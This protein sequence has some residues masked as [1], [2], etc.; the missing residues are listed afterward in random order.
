MFPNWC[1]S[2][3]PVDSIFSVND[4]DSSSFTF[5]VTNVTH[6]VF[7]TSADGDTW[8]DATTF[9]SADLNAG[10]VRFVREDSAAHAD[11]LDPGR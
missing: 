9:T 7:Q 5:T 1:W 3:P 6:G 2:L 10:H 4:P 8:A 11:L